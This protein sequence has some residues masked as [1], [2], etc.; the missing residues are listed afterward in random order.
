MID[1][2]IPLVGGTSFAGFMLI[3]ILAAVGLV[4]G[5]DES[6]N[7]IIGSE[8]PFTIWGFMNSGAD[9]QYVRVFPISDE[10]ALDS[11]ASI[12]ARVFSTN[13]TTGERFE[14]N[15]KTVRFDTLG[16]GHV[17]WSPFRAEFEYEYR[18]EVVRSDGESSSA[19]V[20]VPPAVEF[21]I[22][23]YSQGVT[24]PIRIVGDI[25][26]LVGPKV[27]YHGIN[28]P[29]SSAWPPGTPVHPPVLH[30]VTIPYDDELDSTPDGWRLTINMVADTAAV[31]GDF[32]TNCLITS[33]IYS[34][35]NVWL[36]SMEFTVVIADSSW[37]PP[38]GVFDPDVL[39]VPGTMS[40]VENGYGFY[41]AGQGIRHE[42]APTPESRE[43]AGYRFDARCQMGPFDAD[44]CR[45]P[46]IPCIGENL[47]DVWTLWLR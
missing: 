6:V 19:T 21:E 43:F 39:A 37:H 40:N 20:T 46:P 27:T 42:W 26:N 8:Y 24:I 1:K 4:S 9:T 29:P 36:R 31:R 34:A 11:S 44:E 35:P 25:P 18:L 2:R 12:D 13:I 17:F 41:G 7:P 28:V 45:N 15:Y 32:R 47:E 22:N 33:P 16:T 3:G 10:L 30:S 23:E 5:C 38:G 14:W